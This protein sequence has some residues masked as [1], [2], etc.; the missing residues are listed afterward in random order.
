ML[1]EE[2][3]R[4]ATN[5]HWKENNPQGQKHAELSCS[6]IHASSNAHLHELAF[7]CRCSACTG[8]TPATFNQIQATRLNHIRYKMQLG[9]CSSP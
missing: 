3:P 8:A 9:L 6:A 1:C 2:K 4:S 5:T 7:D